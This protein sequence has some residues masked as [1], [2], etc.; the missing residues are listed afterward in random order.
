MALGRRSKKAS[1]DMPGSFPTSSGENFSLGDSQTSIQ[2]AFEMPSIETRLAQNSQATAGENSSAI[3]DSDSVG[4][5][6]RPPNVFKQPEIDSE[7]FDLIP[8][9]ATVRQDI[10]RED[11]GPSGLYKTTT[12]TTTSMNTDDITPAMTRK[13][14][15]GDV[16]KVLTQKNMSGGDLS[17]ALAMKKASGED[18]FRALTRNKSSGES[19]YRMLSRSMTQLS[20]VERTEHKDQLAEIE[21]LMSHMFGTN[22]QENSQEEQNRHAGLVFRNLTVKGSGLGATLKPTLSDPFLAL[23]RL[24]AGL[25]G[26]GAN[27][28]LHKQPPRIIVNDLTGCVRPGEMLLVLGRPGAGCT[29]FLKVLGNQRTEFEEVA[30]KVTYGGES[31][32]TMKNHYRGDILYNAEEDLHYATLTVQQTLGFA[33]NAKAPGENSRVEGESRSQYITEFLKMVLKLFWI[34]HTM[35][36]KV[37]NE[38]LRGVSGGEKK[39]VS[40]AEVMIT[41]A[42]TQ[43]WDN[44]T[45]GLDASTA[46]EYVEALRTMTNM[47]H[48]STCI[49]LYQ[50]GENLY[51]L[52]DKVMLID[53][54]R[55]LY[56]G[57]T[58][59]AS[60]YFEDMG[61]MRPGRWTTADF[62]TSLVDP[63][64]RQIRQG[65]E[66]TVPRSAEQF[67]TAYRTSAA[68]EANN[69]DIKDFEI[70][71]LTNIEAR[72]PK[73]FEE[74]NYTLSFYKQV[75]ACTHRQFLII[76][77]DRA[78]VGGKCGGIL[79][80]GLIVGSLFY[81]QPKSS[82]GVFTRGG[83]LFFMLLFNALLALAELTSAFVSRPILQKHKSL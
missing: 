47:A 62:L 21:K 68:F 77:G 24:I 34:E 10:F 33:L 2:T 15:S 31:F 41:R 23:P 16:H 36:T 74:K 63:H 79:F 81:D 30:G 71:L 39:R 49:A 46:L 59:G 38:F 67:E 64:E 52:F 18:L 43:C 40:I 37:G 73:T 4:P 6:T 20:E 22:R 69:A 83:V 8:H 57:S 61:F 12:T 72:F 13:H 53:E 78:T 56:F 44:S 55:C 70:P 26:G 1:S 27:R 19:L 42:S 9:F 50:A 32:E 66:N 3:Q 58:A 54:G 28:T 51:E 48:I 5:S 65:F 75:L 80:Q 35:N 45:R 14:T 17:K 7:T 76:L 29:T 25:L 82:S 11:P 60:A